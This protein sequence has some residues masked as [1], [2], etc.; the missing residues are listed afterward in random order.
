V[1]KNE[2]QTGRLHIEGVQLVG[3]YPIAG[4]GDVDV[5][6]AFY[7]NST[8]M[9]A[10]SYTEAFDAPPAAEVQCINPAFR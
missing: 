8:V 5:V 2:L 3:K 9:R 4:Q 7:T 1:V 6:Q 10:F